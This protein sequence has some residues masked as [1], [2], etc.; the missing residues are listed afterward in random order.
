M[1]FPITDLNRNINN[2]VTR[3]VYAEIEIVYGDKSDKEAKRG[4]LGELQRL[5]VREEFP[6]V[7]LYEVRSFGVRQDLQQIVVRD[8]VEPREYASLG[9]Q[10][11]LE[12]LL[13]RLQLVI[14]FVQDFQQAS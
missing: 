6:H 1:C 2:H 10:V 8:E 13:Q 9:F 3:R 12:R 11:L 7:R 5:D 4:H 14:E